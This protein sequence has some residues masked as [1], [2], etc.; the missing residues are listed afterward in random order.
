MDTEEREVGVVAPAPVP[1]D[2]GIVAAMSIEV[3]FLTDRLSKV[4]K[5]SGPSHTVLEGEYGGK[6]VALIVGGMGRDAA[7]RATDVLLAGHRP[8]W[9]LSAG[10]GGG[11]NP[12]LKRN[13]VVMSTEVLNLEGQRYAIDV[14]VPPQG[15]GLRIATGRLLTVDRIV[16]TA[17]EKAELRHRY[18]ADLLD[19]ETSAVAHVCSERS[20][21]FLSIRVVSDEAGVDLPPEV[22]SLMTRSGSYRIGA[23]LRAIWHRPSRLKDFWVLHEHAQEAADRLAQFTVGAIERL[24]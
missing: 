18:D 8:R 1:V 16:R 6:I 11:L 23:A 12:D 17:A 21:R 9:V 20:V 22:A 7:R 4:R 14:V 19:M 2:V 13:T 24:D 3:G 10:F 5:Y 15:R